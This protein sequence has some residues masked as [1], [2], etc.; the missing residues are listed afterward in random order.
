MHVACD[1]VGFLPHD[2]AQLGV[3]LQ[4][5]HTVDDVR[6]RGL[7]AVG[8]A[9]VVALVE[10]RLEFDEHRHLLAGFGRLDEKI[11]ER[12]IVADAVERHLDG[13][14]VRIARG[15]AEERFDRAEGLKRHVHEPLSRCRMSSKSRSC[16][17]SGQIET[18]GNGIEL[19]FRPGQRGQLRPTGR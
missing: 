4:V 2:Q 5:R 9:D 1:A 3:R 13:N 19:Q 17:C 16:S 12:R 14:D 15:G 18:A 11:D 7:Q 8:P 10:P 6:A